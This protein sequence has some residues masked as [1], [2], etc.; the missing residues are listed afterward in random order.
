MNI[1]C[2]TLNKTSLYLAHEVLPVDLGS[3]VCFQLN[4]GR[5]TGQLIGF[6]WVFRLM[7][8]SLN[9]VASKLGQQDERKRAA[10]TQ[11]LTWGRGFTY[12]NF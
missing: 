1:F 10:A 7:I 6:W 4:V 3:A 5:R 12:L 8:G 2:G 11:N 9:P